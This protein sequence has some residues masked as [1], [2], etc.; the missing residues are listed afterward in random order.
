MR[1]GFDYVETFA[2]TAKW[3][4]LRAILA[5]AAL[6]DMEM[7]SLDI[8]SAFLNGVLD[9]EVFM[10]QPEGFPLG[11]PDE[12]LLLK[13]GLYGLKQASRI[14]HI[15][16]DNILCGMGFVKVKSD[17]SIWVYEKDGVKI[18]IPVF[19]DDLTLVS[20]SKEAI[21]RSRRTC[22]SSSSFVTWVPQSSCLESRL[23]GIVPTG[24]CICLKGSMLLIFSV[25]MGLKTAIPSR[26]PFLPVVSR[27]PCLLPLLKM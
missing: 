19:V 17:H 27:H 12:V 5:I 10:E 7:E 22:L 23:R 16:L 6:E 15:K 25:G 18:V 14:W 4:A 2:P 3:A 9:T 21:K 13:R 8:S 24:H 1:P 11:T 20:K 26:L